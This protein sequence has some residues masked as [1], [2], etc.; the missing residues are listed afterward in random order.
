[1]RVRLFVAIVL[2]L[3]VIA[4]ALVSAPAASPEVAGVSLS[5]SVFTASIEDNGA[6][7]IAAELLRIDEILAE[8]ARVKAELEAVNTLRIG[9]EGRT[10][11]D[12][13]G[14]AMCETGGDWSHQSQYDGGLGILHVAWLEF[15]GRDFAEYGSDA[16]REEQIIVA[17]RLHDRHG[18]SGWGCK[19]YG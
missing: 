15:G 9:L 6:M 4:I 14:I 8:A 11:V 1:M 10:G 17:E 16:T 2:V 12:W 5:G 18:L 13:D 7:S 3:F 19:A